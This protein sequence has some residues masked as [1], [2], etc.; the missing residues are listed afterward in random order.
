MTA[1]LV[2]NFADTSNEKAK[3][4]LGWRPRSANEAIIATAQSMIDLGIVT[5]K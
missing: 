2:G 4:L 5:D 1:T 3:T